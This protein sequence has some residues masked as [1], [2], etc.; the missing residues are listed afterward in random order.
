MGD[1]TMF[2]DIITKMG[3]AYVVVHVAV[4]ALLAIE[5]NRDYEGP[6]ELNTFGV[7]MA[8]ALFRNKTF[9]IAF[10]TTMVLGGLYFVLFI[11]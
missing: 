7:H 9:L 3:I 1:Q 2:W 11:K 8:K 4:T 6:K 10:I 5:I